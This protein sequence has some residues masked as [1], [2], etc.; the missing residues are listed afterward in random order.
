[1]ITR[2]KVVIEVIINKKIKKI[3]LLKQMR[4]QKKKLFKK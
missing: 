2:F 1:M 3:K 4:V